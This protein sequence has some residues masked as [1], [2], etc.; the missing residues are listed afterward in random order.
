MFNKLT[1]ESQYRVFDD[2]SNSYQTTKDKQIKRNFNNPFCAIR[3]HLYE[4]SIIKRGD[5]IVIKAYAHHKGREFNHRY[6]RKNSGISSITFNLKT[7]NISCYVSDKAS[8]HSRTK[9]RTNVFSDII[10]GVNSAHGAFRLP[11]NKIK[12]NSKLYGQFKQTFDDMDF[13]TTLIKTLELNL[14]PTYD[15]DYFWLDK[16][17]KELVIKFVTHKKIKAPNEYTN[18]IIYSYPKEK[19]LKKNDR[20]LVESILDFYKL[21]SK[22]LNKFLHLNPNID[23]HRLF[24]LCYLLGDDYT[25]FI[26]NLDFMKFN[27]QTNRDFRYRFDD[28]NNF[29]HLKS[30]IEE[31]KTTTPDFT[32][33]SGQEKNNIISIVNNYLDFALTKSIQRVHVL[34]NDI[35]DHFRLIS[36]VKEY[37]IELKINAKTYE[38]FITEHSEF[39]KINSSIQKGYEIEYFFNEETINKIEEPILLESGDMLYPFILKKESDY[40]EE[41]KHMHHCVASYATTNK[42][43]IISIRDERKH[44]R[45]TCELSKQDARLIQARHFC[46]A[47]PPDIFNHAIDEIVTRCEYLARFGMLNHAKEERVPITINGIVIKKEHRQPRTLL[48]ILE[49]DLTDAGHI[50]F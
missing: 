18:L 40:I 25:K 9:F 42:S 16:F 32:N 37:G 34:L 20:K 46:N 39:S 23:F 45:V 11:I 17:F 26:C 33:I 35:C 47:T 22:I 50:L 15:I 13:T 21:K 36:L 5:K 3:T 6:F 19:F 49:N 43:I 12:S 31:S 29:K 1:Y 44:D 38:E 2:I 48:D 4:R 10:D 28:V 24:I 7:G 8:K 41:G 14:L 27:E 30:R